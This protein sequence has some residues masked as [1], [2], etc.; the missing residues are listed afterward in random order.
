MR[1]GDRSALVFFFLAMTVAEIR[2][3][4]YGS[5]TFLPVLC[6]GLHVLYLHD[7]TVS[8]IVYGHNLPIHVLYGHVQI[9]TSVK[10][11]PRSLQ[12]CP[13]LC[14]NVYV[15]ARSPRIREAGMA[16]AGAGRVGLPSTQ[17][18]HAH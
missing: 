13:S 15:S 8:Y 17:S 9:R 12:P 4:Q 6:G 2:T 3:V 11:T 5:L 1:V 16:G 14:V 10:Y 18:N 7:F